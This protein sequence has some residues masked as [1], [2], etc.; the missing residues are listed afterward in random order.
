MDTNTNKNT[1]NRPEGTPQP[2]MSKADAAYQEQKNNNKKGND[3]MLNNNNEIMNQEVEETI[4]DATEV[5]RR[6][7]K[8]NNEN[9]GDN[10][11]K[12]NQCILV[13]GENHELVT[14]VYNEVFVGLFENAATKISEIIDNK[15]YFNLNGLS[16]DDK[17]FISIALR[18]RLENKEYPNLTIQNWDNK[19]NKFRT[20]TNESTQKLITNLPIV[21]NQNLFR[22]TIEESNINLFETMMIDEMMINEEQVFSFN[23]GSKIEYIIINLPTD[24]KELM[25]NKFENFL[26]DVEDE[27]R[28]QEHNENMNQAMKRMKRNTTSIVTDVI[29]IGDNVVSGVAEGFVA[30]VQA[31]RTQRAIEKQRRIASQQCNYEYQYAKQLMSQEPSI[32]AKIAMVQEKVSNEFKK[33]N[34]TKKAIRRQR[35]R[36]TQDNNNGIYAD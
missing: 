23:F 29:R 36:G 33:Y 31:V 21:R 6:K 14:R 9:K 1:V 4:E 7:R 8:Q 34:D 2:K 11:M 20:F 5:V 12:Y 27:I 30:G 16:E 17:M 10:S 32:G 25:N 26:E 24:K 13:N 15:L 3:T 19:Q 35:R 22:A 18:T 28:K